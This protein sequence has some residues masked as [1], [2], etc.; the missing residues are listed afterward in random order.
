[1]DST[2]LGYQ[3]LKK[4]TFMRATSGSVMRSDLYKRALLLAKITVFY[5]LL[6]GIVSVFFGMEDETLSLFGFGIDSFVEVISGTGI[7]HMVRRINHQPADNTDAFER[8]ALQIT[9]SAFYLLT[10]GLT[11]TAAIN[12]YS[13]HCPETTFWGVVISLVSI[14]TMW[15][16]IH[17][18]MNVGRQL[19]SDAIIADAGCTR[20]CLYLSFVLLA[21]S[22]GYELTGI[23]GLDSLGAIAIAVFSFKEGREAFE[24]AQGKPCSCCCHSE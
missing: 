14:A 7:W 13:G 11:L 20:T 17:F 16:L 1:M 9:G 3:T 12:L 6:E 8:K 2:R 21:A 23:G 24:K 22:V 10:V 19:K 4:D 18:K 5:N 15:A